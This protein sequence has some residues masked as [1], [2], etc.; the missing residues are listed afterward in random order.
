MNQELPA[1]VETRDN[2]GFVSDEEMTSD[3]DSE[4]NTKN[5]NK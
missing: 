2:Q 4:S 5:V 3:D 1:E